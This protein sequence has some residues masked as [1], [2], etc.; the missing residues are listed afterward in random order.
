MFMPPVGK[1]RRRRRS[2]FANTQKF[3]E[4]DDPIPN[5]MKQLVIQSLDF[6]LRLE[7]CS[8]SKSVHQVVQV[9]C[10]KN[11]I[12]IEKSR[13]DSMQD[14]DRKFVLEHLLMGTAKISGIDF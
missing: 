11:E 10:K 3:C 4:T 6:F 1:K 12:S 2:I 5:W 14:S 9:Q 7:N 8:K 13:L